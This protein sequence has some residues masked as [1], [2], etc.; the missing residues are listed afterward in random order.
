[1]MGKNFTQLVA[2]AEKPRGKPMCSEEEALRL[3]R[4]SGEN[5]RRFRREHRLKAGRSKTALGFIVFN[6]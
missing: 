2:E 3:Y 1:M 6:A 4:E 5:L